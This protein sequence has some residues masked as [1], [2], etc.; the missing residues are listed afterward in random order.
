MEYAVR[1][2]WSLLETFAWVPW[3]LEVISSSLS[4]SRSCSIAV[5]I[6]NVSQPKG[7]PS[8]NG[9]LTAN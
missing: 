5:A 6:G 1:T 7:D 2:M 8:F 3:Q 9:I 4:D